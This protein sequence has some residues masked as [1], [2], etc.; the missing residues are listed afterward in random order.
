MP[1]LARRRD[2][3]RLDVEEPWLPSPVARLI[4][5]RAACTCRGDLIVVL[6]P[7]SSLNT[8]GLELESTAICN[9]FGKWACFGS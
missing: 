8:A 4:L 2:R 1:K 5:R 7:A 9:V 6:A 3:A